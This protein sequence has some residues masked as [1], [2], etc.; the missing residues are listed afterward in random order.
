MANEFTIGQM[1]RLNAT[2]VKTLRYY[3]QL[4]LLKP[5]RI[6]QDSGYR[7]YTVAQFE[8]LNTIQY[9]RRLG[10]SL[11]TI[12]QH[13]KQPDTDAFLAMLATQRTQI[14]S[15][16]AALNRTAAQLT[17]RYHDIQTAAG[18]PVAQPFLQTL[19]T[20]HILKL[21]TEIS[22]NV[23]LELA[24]HRLQAAAEIYIGGVGLLLDLAALSTARFEQYSGIFVL[25]EQATP[26]TTV[27]EAGEYACLR[28]NG[29]HAQAAPYY[30]TLLTWIH[31]SG[32]K[33]CGA[34]CERTIID[35]DISS[36][37]A[38]YRTEIQI[39]IRR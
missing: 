31:V 20:R 6:A 38:A 35:Q 18:A 37:P 3:D 15:Q 23:D 7:Y 11:A 26:E 33:P 9:L 29:N 16:I 1:A 34:A 39:P 17:A 25:V 14:Q 4:G 30:R 12:Q 27:L 28:F 8:R 36:D 32:K 2:T 21:D 5:A 13:L 24:L 19:P 10:L 22:H